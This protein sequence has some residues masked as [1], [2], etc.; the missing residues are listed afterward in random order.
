MKFQAR[1][2]WLFFV[3]LTLTSFSINIVF[4]DADRRDFVHRASDG[5]LEIAE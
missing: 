2:K 1:R 5:A 3:F 4:G